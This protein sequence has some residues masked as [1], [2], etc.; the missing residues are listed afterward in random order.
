MFHSYSKCVN[1]KAQLFQKVHVSKAAFIARQALTYPQS[2]IKPTL[3]KQ[4][5]C[6]TATLPFTFKSILRQKKNYGNSNI[7]P[8]KNIINLQ[9]N[10]LKE[11]KILQDHYNFMT[12]L[13]FQHK[14][15]ISFFKNPHIETD[16]LPRCQNPLSYYVLYNQSKHNILA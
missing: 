4:G 7:S 14:A 15:K 5:V 16:L 9:K 8:C 12:N 6:H 3:I 1:T 2:I 10:P 11:T 13:K